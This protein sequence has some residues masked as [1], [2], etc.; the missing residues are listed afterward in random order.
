MLVWWNELAASK[1]DGSLS[2]MLQISELPST[3]TSQIQKTLFS[4]F[5]TLILVRASRW[6]FLSCAAKKRSQRRPPRP[7]RRPLTADKR[8]GEKGCSLAASLPLFR[9]PEPLIPRFGVLQGDF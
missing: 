5:G 8:L 4:A 6:T 2:G 7:A 1:Y 3:L 9:N